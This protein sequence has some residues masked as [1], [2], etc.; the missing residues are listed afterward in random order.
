MIKYLFPFI[1]LFPLNLAA[2]DCCLGEKTYIQA[3]EIKEYQVLRPKK[4]PILD[5]LFPCR[6]K[7]VFLNRIVETRPIYL[8][9]INNYPKN[10]K[11]TTIEKVKIKEKVIQAELKSVI[12]E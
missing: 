1:L 3:Y 10:K 12:E 8:E 7:R 2:Q 11:S 5:K 4:R 9:N 6:K